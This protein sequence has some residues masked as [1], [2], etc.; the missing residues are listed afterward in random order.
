ML[1]AHLGI[2]R[3]LE[4]RLLVIDIV[5]IA[6][7]VLA[8][9]Y[10]FAFVVDEGY[11]VLFEIRRV[12]LDFPIAHIVVARPADVVGV[13]VCDALE[14]LLRLQVGVCALDIADEILGVVIHAKLECVL[15]IRLVRSDK[16]HI[17][18]ITIVAQNGGV[19]VLDFVP[20]GVTQRRGDRA[21]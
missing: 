6:Q 12:Q 16:S 20:C 21:L 15:R 4:I 9:V 1:V 5:Y 8:L 13:A 2:H 19:P 7:L 17:R 18:C 11:A 10:I 3:R 14:V